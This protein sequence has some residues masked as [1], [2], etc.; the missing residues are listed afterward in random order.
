MAQLRSDWGD[1][2]LFAHAGGRYTATA[3]FGQREVLSAEDPEEL[4]ARIRRHYRRDPPEERCSTWRR[5]AHK[6]CR[7]AD[8]GCNAA[9]K[10]SARPPPRIALCGS[11]ALRSAPSRPDDNQGGQDRARHSLRRQRRGP[12]LGQKLA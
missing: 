9:V 3:R 4:L 8:L 7:R 5:C 2:Y 12:A 10:A 1:V 11:C 6:A